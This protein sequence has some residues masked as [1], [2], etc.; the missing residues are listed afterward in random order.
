MGL[1]T[2]S[3]LGYRKAGVAAAAAMLFLPAGDA[4][5]AG[6]AAELFVETV[7]V[8]S[9]ERVPETSHLGPA[10]FDALHAGKDSLEEFLRRL[11][12]EKRGNALDLLS[13]D[14]RA[15]YGSPGQFLRDHIDAEAI[16]SYRI[17]DYVLCA[18]RTHIIFRFLLTHTLEGVH[19]T[20]QR[21]IEL[22]N[23]AGAW[24]IVAFDSTA[25]GC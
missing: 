5:A 13:P 18:N 11:N 8:E 19:M 20:D 16:L 17:I 22:R 2:R 1:F 24:K 25:Q 14:L 21:S 23:R 3:T 4:A 6:G 15:R 9:V 12:S 10:D 7:I